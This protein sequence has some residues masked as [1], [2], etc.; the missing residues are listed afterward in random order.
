MTQ[1]TEEKHLFGDFPAIDSDEDVLML[2]GIDLPLG[3]TK[4]K[5]IKIYLNII[6]VQ[7]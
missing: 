1:Y 6:L 7:G 3:W 4:R 2:G 5:F